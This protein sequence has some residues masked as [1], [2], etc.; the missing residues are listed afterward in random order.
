[1]N[2]PS[3]ILMRETSSP[4]ILKTRAARLRKETGNPNL[5]AASDRQIPFKQLMVDALARPVGFLTRSPIVLLVALYLAFIFGVIML[6]FATFPPMFERVYHWSVAVSGLGYIGIGVGCAVGVVLFAKL[7]DRQLRGTDDNTGGRC[8]HRPERRLILMMYTSPLVSVGLFIYGWT[9]AYEVHWVVP[10]IGT[11][12][13]GIG[14]VVITSSSSTHIIDIFG[15]Q[16]AASA[17]G[18]VSVLRNLTG[19]FLPLAAAPLYQHLGPG[20]GNSVLAFIAAAFI[21]VPFFFYR[22]GEWLRN[23]FPVKA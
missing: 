21:P 7:S 23:R 3:F 17:L 8:N 22:R 10:I 16:T 12:V 2:I 4:A 19:S 15:P 9:V 5:R 14:V 18:A 1:M 13:T 6:F 11:A 20:W